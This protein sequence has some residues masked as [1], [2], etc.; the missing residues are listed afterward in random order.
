MKLILNEKET[1]EYLDNQKSAKQIYKA[2]NELVALCHQFIKNVEVDE[3]GKIRFVELCESSEENDKIVVKIFYT[4]PLDY[5]QFE[6]DK[7]CEENEN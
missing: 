5:P 4:L 1:K 3:Y 7:E 6:D 2:Y